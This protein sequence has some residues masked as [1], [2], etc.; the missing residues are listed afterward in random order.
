M[1]NLNFRS[2]ADAKLVYGLKNENTVHESY[3]SLKSTF[4]QLNMIKYNFEISYFVFQ[5][6]KNIL[7]IFTNI[8]KN[9]V[10]IKK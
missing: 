3:E 6:R 2:V 1:N 8:S 4:I 9:V 5:I 7:H 10:R